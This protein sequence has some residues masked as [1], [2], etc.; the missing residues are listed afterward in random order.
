M[1]NTVI[2]KKPIKAHGKDYTS[3]TFRE[4][5]GDEVIELG[6]PFSFGRNK[7]THIDTEVTAEYIMRLANIP[8]SSVKMLQP[9]DITACFGKIAGFFG[10]SEATT[11]SP[12][13]S[14]EDTTNSPGSTAAA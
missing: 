2:L 11:S 4:P 13:N 9:A 1:N 6:V 14:S 10:N 12:D 3:L 8:M 7:R 5:T